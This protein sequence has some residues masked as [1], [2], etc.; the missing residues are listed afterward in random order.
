MRFADRVLVLLLVLA[1]T[2]AATASPLRIRNG[3]ATN[4][5]LDGKRQSALGLLATPKGWRLAFDKSTTGVVE[6]T[7]V[8]TG[9]PMGRQSVRL[10]AGT[11]ELE[12]ESFIP[13]HA[14]SAKVR[15]TTGTLLEA[16]IYLYPPKSGGTVTFDANEDAAA[17]GAIAVSEKGLL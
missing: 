2:L 17:D 16:L 12:R 15:V 11:A 8:T 10:T 3:R 5:S 14:Y 4:V 13:G 1:H 7:D 6:L 9:K